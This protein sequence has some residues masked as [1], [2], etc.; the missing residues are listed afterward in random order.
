MTVFETLLG[1]FIEFL[2]ILEAAQ[3]LTHFSLERSE[4]RDDA[5]FVTDDSGG[6]L[7]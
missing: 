2:P 5:G 4:V 7:G 1:R 3:H 6:A